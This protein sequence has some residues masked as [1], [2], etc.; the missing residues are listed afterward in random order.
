L[1]G[2][3]PWRRAEAALGVFDRIRQLRAEPANATFF[4]VGTGRVPVVPLF[5]W[6]MGAKRTIT[7]D[8]NRYLSTSLTLAAMRQ[9]AEQRS[10]LRGLLGERLVIDRLAYLERQLDSAARRPMVEVLASLGIDYRA[11][12]DAAHTRIEDGSIDFH[13]SYTVLEHVAEASIRSM[14]CGRSADAGAC[15][16]GGTLHRLL[17]SL[18]SF[19]SLNRRNS[20]PAL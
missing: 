16:A 9:I 18:Q 19:G 12:S 14:S 6:L 5:L 10:E 1:R 17:G 11:P 8:L 7:V 3:S 4:E 2:Y 15:R 20:F 13:I